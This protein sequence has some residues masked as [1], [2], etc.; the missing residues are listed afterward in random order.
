MHFG[1]LGALGA[2]ALGASQPRGWSRVAVR[3]RARSFLSEDELFENI[4][5]TG[6]K[7]TEVEKAFMRFVLGSSAR[8]LFSVG[9][10]R[11]LRSFLA[12]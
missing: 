1:A 6:H 2:S 8:M 11:S 3:A 7:M 12:Q 10:K 9:E 5:N 4:G